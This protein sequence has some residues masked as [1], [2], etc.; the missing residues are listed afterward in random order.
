MREVA[1]LNIDDQAPEE[2]LAALLR[3]L[4]HMPLQRVR[5]VHAEFERKLTALRRST[6][7]HDEVSYSGPIDMDCPLD[8][9]RFCQ[10]AVEM[11][12]REISLRARRGPK[13]SEKAEN[14]F[15]HS[16]DF[17]TIRFRDKPYV[18]TSQQAQVVQFLYEASLRG[19][20]TVSKDRV[21]E[22]I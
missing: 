18:L 10:Q 20:S 5:R 22:H 15:E 4:P 1:C 21:L 19:E 8:Q 6:P 16:E 7:G 14:K 12:S 9:I 2:F 3:E 13:A 17:R 11:C